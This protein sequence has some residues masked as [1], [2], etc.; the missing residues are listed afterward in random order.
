MP[1]PA[2]QIGGVFLSN[3]IGTKALAVPGHLYGIVLNPALILVVKAGRSSNGKL[4]VTLP[5]PNNPW[6]VGQNVYFQGLRTTGSTGD[7]TRY[8]EVRFY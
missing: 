6:L 7:F 5:V 4:S 2:S 3:A 8:I 1:L